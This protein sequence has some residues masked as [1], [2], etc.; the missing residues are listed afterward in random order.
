MYTIPGTT[1]IVEDTCVQKHSFG[2]LLANNNPQNLSIELKNSFEPVEESTHGI[3]F[4][5]KQIDTNNYGK[6]KK[7]II[8]FIFHGM[9]IFDA[10]HSSYMYSDENKNL[11]KQFLLMNKNRNIIIIRI[12]YSNFEINYNNSF[13]KFIIHQSIIFNDLISKY[14]NNNNDTPVTP[15]YHFI[16]CFTVFFE[17]DINKFRV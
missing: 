1:D 10:R 11:A 17:K 6:K 7:E 13:Q 4:V 16:K 15:D 2:T 5:C 8:E 14:E 3:D 9:V 12:T